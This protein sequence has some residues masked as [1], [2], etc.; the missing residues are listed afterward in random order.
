[1]EVVSSHL[2]GFKSDAVD[3]IAI[4]LS[5]SWIGLG[6]TNSLVLS[7]VVILGQLPLWSRR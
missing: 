5:R 1:M 2:V 7:V 4:A 6:Y 3:A